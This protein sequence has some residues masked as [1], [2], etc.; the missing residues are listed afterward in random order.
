MAREKG[1]RRSV[2]PQQKVVEIPLSQL[3]L[4]TEN[5]RDPLD[6]DLSNEEIIAHALHDDSKR[7]DLRK[8]AQKMGDHYDTSE[9][10]TVVRIDEGGGPRYQVYDGNRRVILALLQQEGFP[11]DGDQFELPLVPARLPCNV[12][13]QD[14]AMEHV[15]RKHSNNGTWGRYERDL[16]MHRYMNADKSVLVRLQELADAVTRWPELNQRYV[17]DEVL[18][19]RHLREMGLDPEFEDYG[20]SAEMMDELLQSIATALHEGRIGTRKNRN[21][22]VSALPQDLL[23]KIQQD[24]ESHPAGRKMRH[25]GCADGE[26]ERQPAAEDAPRP[27]RIE[28]EDPQEMAL[29]PEQEQSEQER[30]AGSRRT[31]QARR[32]SLAVFGGGLPLRPGAVNNIYRTLDELWDLNEQGKL[33]NSQSF[34]A[35]FRMGLRLLAETATAEDV[36]EEKTP[37]LSMYVKK[38]AAKA[39]KNLRNRADGQDIVTYLDTQAVTPDSMIKMLQSGAHGYTSTN[40][41]EQA[42]ALSILLGQMLILSHGRE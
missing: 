20:V 5:P 7:W 19:D 30:P 40:N 3:R 9:L 36:G 14:T 27:S 4:W 38:Y 32:K 16:F 28:H 37:H 12:C 22:P 21:D 29:F 11:E 24:R 42:I 8:F 13:D 26:T 10:P 39:K 31:R 23:A 18:N 41:R 2:L 17:R 33:K 35:V 1:V 25:A 15:L 6:G 34:I